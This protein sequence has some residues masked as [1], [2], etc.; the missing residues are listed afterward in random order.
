MRSVIYLISCG[1][2]FLFFTWVVSAVGYGNFCFQ[3]HQIEKWHDE[4]KPNP[5]PKP[6][7]TKTN[8]NY[9]L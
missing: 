6:N 3:W 5:K 1:A 7:Q 9:D 8:Q 4:N 2:A